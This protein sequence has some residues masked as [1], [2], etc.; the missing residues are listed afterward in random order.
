[1]RH[2]IDSII[3]LYFYWKTYKEP[4]HALFNYFRDNNLTLNE[5]ANL[6]AIRYLM[7]RT[8]FGNVDMK[9]FDFI[10]FQE[11]YAEDLLSLSRLLSIP[12]D[13]NK[14]NINIFTNYR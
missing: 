10:G 2:P 6:P 4:A 14:E 8:Y 7:S 11:T 12:I 3:S 9:S 5:L 13:E 1:M